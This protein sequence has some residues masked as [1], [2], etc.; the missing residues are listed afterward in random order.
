MCYDV[1]HKV[2]S[3]RECWLCYNVLRCVTQ[4][5][6]IKRMLT[7]LQCVAQASLREMFAVL[8]HDMY[9]AVFPKKPDRKEWMSQVKNLAGEEDT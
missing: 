7:V 6:L 5:G 8:Q 9:V 1:S 3:L 4:G 2:A